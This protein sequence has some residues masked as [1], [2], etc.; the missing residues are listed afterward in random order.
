MIRCIKYFVGILG[1]AFDCEG[2]IAV[3]NKIPCSIESMAGLDKQSFAEYVVCPRCNAIYEFKNCVKNLPSGKTE[4]MTCRHV[5]YPNHPHR[6][7]ITACGAPLLK[8]QRN[9]QSSMLVPIKV[10]P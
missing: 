2:I 9:K 5:A 3:S 1:K 7:R 4:T 6:S 10:Y 8:K